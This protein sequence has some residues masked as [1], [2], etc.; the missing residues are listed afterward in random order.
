MVW[1]HGGAFVTGE[2]RDYDPTPLVE[3]GVMVVTINY[4][5]GFLGFFAHPPLDAEGHL[6]ANYW[7][8]DQQLAL[9][10]V[11]RNITAF[12]GDPSRVAIVGQSAG[13]TSV[14]SNLASPRAAGLFHRTV[15]ESATM[16]LFQKFDTMPQLVDAE[17]EV[18]IKVAAS[19]GRG[20]QTGQC[21]RATAASEFVAQQLA[22][23]RGKTWQRKWQWEPKP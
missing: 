12:G 2:S 15:A 8:M 1:I 4:R 21:L 19:A 10:W 9:K 14:Y 3:R 11:Q 17:N 20:N 23:Q 22:R 16:T 5:L 6:N 13:G 7:L 18:G